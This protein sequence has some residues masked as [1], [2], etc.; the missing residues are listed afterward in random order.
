MKD[1][2]DSSSSK[3]RHRISRL[4]NKEYWKNNSPFSEESIKLFGE[5]K[6]CY[7]RFC[8]KEY[9]RTQEHWGTIL[10]L[11]KLF[12]IIRSIVGAKSKVTSFTFFRADS[13]ILS[14][15]SMILTC[16]THHFPY[17][18]SLLLMLLCDLWQIC[19]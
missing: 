12:L 14:K 15:I 5:K 8:Y 16:R 11:G 13:S 7:K 2:S 19:W 10:A 4:K 3:E 6:R 9:P 18:L 17:L 1:R